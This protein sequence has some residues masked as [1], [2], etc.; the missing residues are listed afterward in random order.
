MTI[1]WTG[2]LSDFRTFWTPMVAAVWRDAGGDDLVE[3]YG[4]KVV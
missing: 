4:Y 2:E 3:A 1:T